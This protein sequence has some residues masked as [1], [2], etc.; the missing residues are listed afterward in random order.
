VHGADAGHRTG[1]PTDS[2]RYVGHVVFN[3]T[4]IQIIP[5]NP[6]N[7]VRILRIRPPKRQT[8]RSSVRLRPTTG[9]IGAADSF[10]PVL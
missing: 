9:P 6:M 3:L 2:L 4:G 8:G 7:L 1:S 5:T 10:P